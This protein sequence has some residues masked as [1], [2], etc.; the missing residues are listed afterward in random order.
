MSTGTRQNHVDYSWSEKGPART[1]STAFILG[2]LLGLGLGLIL[3]SDTLVG[4]GFYLV[5]LALFHLWEYLWVSMYD[6]TL[7]SSKSF[8]INHSSAFNFALLLGFVEFWIE[9]YLFPSMKSFG[10]LNMLGALTMFVGQAFRTKAMIKAGT[11]F[12]HIVQDTKRSDHKLV[13]DGIYQYMRHPSYF[14]WFVWSVSTQLVQFNPICI[15]GYAWASWRFFSERIEDEEDFLVGF[16][17]NDYKEY[18]K[19]VWSGIPLIK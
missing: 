10:Y 8:L 4:Y 12:S 11:N 15:V 3:L 17:G 6:H 2:G 16:F 7:L 13:T 18:R 19:R 9:W 5:G 14:G 1:V